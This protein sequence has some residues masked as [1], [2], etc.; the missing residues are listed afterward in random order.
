MATPPRWVVPTAFAAAALALFLLPGLLGPYGPFIDELYYVSCA[1]RLD[2]G[3]VDHPPLAPAVLHLSRL[4]LGD[5][6]IA[7]RLPAALAGALTVLLVGL[8][9]RRLG[10]GPFGQALACGSLL[11]A[12]LD[13]VFFGFFSMNPF[14]ILIWLTLAFVLAEV[15]LRSEPRLWMAFGL[16]AGIGLQ[17]KH[18]TVLLALALAPALLLTPARRHLRGRWL[19]AGLAVALLLLLPNLIWQAAYGFPSVELYHNA[20]VH[21]NVPTP[22]LQALGLQVLMMSPGTLPVWL[23]G[24]VALLRRRDLRHVGVMCLVLL[25]ATVIAGKSRPDRVAGIYPVLL[26][27]GGTQLEGIAARPAWR[28]LRAAVPISILAV[29]IVLAPVGLP[30][31][32][33]ASQ[34]RWVSAL[35]VVPPIEQGAGKRTPLPQWFADRLGWEQLVDDVAA[36][37]GR[38]SPEERRRALFFA[39]SYGQAGALDWLGRERGLGPVYCTHNTWY[40]WG[41]PADPV[42]VAVVLGNDPEPLAELFEEVELAGIHDCD[43]CMPWRD[44]MPIWVVRRAKVSIAELWPEW[45]HYE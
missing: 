35:G 10:A 7:L 20:D 9:A 11:T 41:P 19:W 28:W 5:G 16:V 43:L 37:A 14:E 34:A 6:L 27:A 15:E 8:L 44:Q 42:D 30:L 29:G 22:P 24:L 38:L 31:L 45:K 26:A 32:P 25:A 21:K 3:Y 13:Q 23:A 40:L 33:P 36:A 2:W 12:P 4:L 1:E 17:N 39:P 18:T